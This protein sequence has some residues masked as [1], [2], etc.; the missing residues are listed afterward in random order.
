MFYSHR[1]HTRPAG[2]H[3][4]FPIVLCGGRLTQQYIVEAWSII[5]D[6]QLKWI[7]D[8]QKELRRDVYIGVVDALAQDSNINPDNI[9]KRFILPSSYTGSTRFMLQ[10]FQD[11]MAIV[12]AY[13]KPTFFITV[14]DTQLSNIERYVVRRYFCFWYRLE[15]LG[16][17][18]ERHRQLN[19]V[20]PLATV[21]ERDDVEFR[22]S[23]D[24]K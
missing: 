19:Q 24:C 13:G 4:E 18:H 11:S 23:L 16:V 10:C 1:L 15:L 21:L 17:W 22:A 3:K 14:S 6:A 5:E 2:L 9:G 20:N 12:G 8:H 7:R